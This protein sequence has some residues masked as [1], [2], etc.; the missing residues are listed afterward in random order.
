MRVKVLLP[1]RRAE[2]VSSNIPEIVVNNDFNLKMK[3]LQPN[4][5]HVRS[6]YLVECPLADKY[7][8]TSCS[9]TR[10]AAD[11]FNF[12]SGGA[13]CSGQRVDHVTGS[14]RNNLF[15]IQTVTRVLQGATLHV[16]YDKMFL[17][18]AGLLDLLTSDCPTTQGGATVSPCSAEIQ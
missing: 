4:N 7:Q 8:N 2:H 9:I 10:F 6:K 3:T 18:E 15:T 5:H 17:F 1:S 13:T 12:P 14:G 16:T 11:I